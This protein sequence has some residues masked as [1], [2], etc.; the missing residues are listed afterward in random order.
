VKNFDTDFTN[1]MVCPHCGYE[2][3]DC[4]EYGMKDGEELQ[5]ECHSCG[6]K[7]SVTCYISI[8]YSTE[9]VNQ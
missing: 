2:D 7:F 9:K 3:G 8:N 4:W 1:N 5:T 6:K